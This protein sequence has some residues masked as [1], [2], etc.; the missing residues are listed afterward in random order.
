MML[1]RHRRQSQSQSL[2]HDV[3]E[4]ILS[5]LPVKS[6]LRFKCVSKQWK[7]TIESRRFKEA[8]LRQSQQSRGGPDI[9][10]VT[11]N[12][13]NHYE[14]EWR[15][16][17][18][19]SSIFV[20]M[21][22][23]SSIRNTKVC[24]GSCDG[25]IC[26]FTVH[27]PNMVA[28]PATR[29]HR[30]FPLS[31]VQQLLSTMYK[32]GA[33]EAPNNQLGFGKDKFTG[34]YKPVWLCNSSEFG[35]DKATATTCEVFDFST[36]AWRY[37]LPSCPYRILDGLKPVYFDGSLFWLTE[38]SKLLSFDLHTETF[39]VICKA[40]FSHIPEPCQVVM[41]ILNNTLCLSQR[42]WPAQVIWSLHNNTTWKE[43]CTIDLTKTFSVPEELPYLPLPVALPLALLE[44]NNKLL[45]GPALD[46]PMVMLD[47]HANNY[48]NVFSPGGVFGYPVSHFD[49]LFSVVSPN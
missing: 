23:F 46:Q 20:R 38:C 14:A 5:R 25:L 34:T 16:L 21:L 42:N 8:Q 22:N 2:P 40:P 44:K 37:V 47:L 12:S 27:T 10:Y 26:L 35:L 24:H 41:C 49:S 13:K 36:N 1:R 4:L 31:R 11:K 6:L 18:G 39:Q 43:M 45:F 28:N 17:L 7:S 32:N 9:L 30:S 48:H 15:I 19:S 3:V 33:W 29:W